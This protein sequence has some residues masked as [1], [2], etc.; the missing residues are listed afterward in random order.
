MINPIYSC[1]CG[2][3]LFY[4]FIHTYSERAI[5]WFVRE[6]KSIVVKHRSRNICINHGN[7]V[8]GLY[9][10]M[11]TDVA[12]GCNGHN[13]FIISDTMDRSKFSGVC[14]GWFFCG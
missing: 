11:R 3:I 13:E 5:L 8:F 12:V 7:R 9:V 2:I 4:I 14:V 1:K 10:A 6:A